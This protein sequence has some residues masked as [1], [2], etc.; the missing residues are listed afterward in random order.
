MDVLLQAYREEPSYP[1]I[2]RD[3]LLAAVGFSEDEVDHN[4]WLLAEKGFVETQAYLNERDAGYDEV[5][6]TQLGRDVTQ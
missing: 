5:E 1:R 4:L 3:D 6:I 2:D